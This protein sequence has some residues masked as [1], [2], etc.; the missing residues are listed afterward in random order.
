L[1]NSR[2]SAFSSA[3]SGKSDSQRARASRHSAPAFHNCGAVGYPTRLTVSELV[4]PQRKM[5]PVEGAISLAASLRSLGF[6]RMV[7]MV[8][9]VVM[10]VM[11]RLCAWNRAHRERKGG[12]G[13]QCESKF[14]HEYHSS[15]GFLKCPKDGESIYARQ[16]DIYEW[17]F[18]IAI[19]RVLS[20]CEENDVGT[21]GLMT[22]GNMRS[23]SRRL[24]ALLVASSSKRRA[25]FC[26]ELPRHTE[27]TYESLIPL[28]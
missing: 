25:P 20:Q 13:G 12:N 17:P 6:V 1:P 5:A 11:F 26:T 18:R 8:M 19:N 16:T 14:S 3:T 24:R 27:Q 22:S 15:A 7:V 2:G 21:S 23:K 4:S 10:F 28:N 9:F